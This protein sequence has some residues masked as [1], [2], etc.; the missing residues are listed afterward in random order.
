MSPSSTPRFSRGSRRDRDALEQRRLRA[1]RLFAQ[2]M[3][4]AEVARELEVSRQSATV[5]HRAWQEEQST[6]REHRRGIEVGAMSGSPRGDGLGV[7]GTPC[8]CPGTS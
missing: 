5:W 2:G 6:I 3:R 4:P 7:N 8:A 1:A